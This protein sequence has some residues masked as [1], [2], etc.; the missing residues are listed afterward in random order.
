MK[1]KVNYT[2]YDN[3]EWRHFDE[4]EIIEA[5]SFEEVKKIIKNKGGFDYECFLERA[6]KIE[7]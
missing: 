2:M 3:N 7:D 6:E 4:E 1:W 5:D